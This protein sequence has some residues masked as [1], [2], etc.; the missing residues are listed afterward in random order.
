MLYRLSYA[1][2]GSRAREI[3]AEHRERAAR[4]QPE[5][6]Y[7]AQVPGRQLSCSRGG[8]A[9][10][11]LALTGQVKGGAGYSG[12][13][14]TEAKTNMD[15]RHFAAA[16]ALAAASFFT[17][18]PAAQ[19]AGATATATVNLRSGPGTNFHV[20]GRVHRGDRVFITRCQNSGRWCH[21]ERR[22]GRDG[23]MSS[24]YLSVR[25]G[26][27][28]RGHGHHRRGSICFHSAHGHVCVNR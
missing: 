7:G 24:R 17:T 15:L 27:H 11:D 26:N 28:W 6:P 2:R 10:L 22:N 1:L 13:P 25:G 19:A 5:K 8:E 14:I 18:L 16:I 3:A 4:G 9:A 23:W 20:I 21:V 12:S